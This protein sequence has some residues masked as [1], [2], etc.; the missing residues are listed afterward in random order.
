MTR[1]YLGRHVLGLAAILFGIVTL[2]WHDFNNWQQ[3]QAL[4]NVPHHEILAYIAAA[5]ELLGGLAIQW[6]RTARAGAVALGSIFFVFALLWVPHIVAE[7][8]VY[9]RWGNL[10]EQLSQVAGALVVYATLGRSDSERAP[11]AAR[12]GYILF[13]ICVVSFTLEQLFYLSATA[14]FVPKWIPP[15]QMFWA[16]TTTIAFALVAIA[17]LSGRSALLTSRLLTAM[18]IGFGLLVWL[19]A[20]FADP[21]KLINWA[22]NAENLAIT[23]AAWIVTDFLS[24]SVPSRWPPEARPCG[25]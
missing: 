19:P 5:I 23:G 9:D 7:P 22:G 12:I 1:I 15:G 6:T 18:L 4:G 10:F 14:D 16:I 11:R 17:L 20:P 25:S 2:V 21:H 13:G 3:I 24:Q 8:R